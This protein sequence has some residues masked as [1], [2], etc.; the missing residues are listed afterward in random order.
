VKEMKKKILV[1]TIILFAVLG[2]S[3]CDKKV[4]N[5]DALKFKEDYEK[6]NGVVNESNGNTYRT[7]NISEDNAFVYKT[8]DEIVDMMNNKETF[9][10]YFGFNTCPWCR[11]VIETLDSV[12]KD[13]KVDTIY[14]VNIRPDGVD[15]RDTITVNE[16]KTYETTKEG[17]KGYYK[18]LEL[19]D[20]VLANYSRTDSE[21]NSIDVNEKRIYAPNLVAVVNGKAI[22]LD[23]GISSLQ[24]D[25]YME[26]TD[27]MKKETY[28][29]FE[30]VLKEIKGTCDTKEAC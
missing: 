13:L 1:F 7:V 22:K 20:S 8:E 28:S 21:G 29:K 10:V 16:D 2:V 17:T 5:E 24:T 26:L 9:A 11:S 12:S 3:G 19:M 23:T 15:I 14:Y 18:L 4:K 25:A 6:Y 27:D 30:S